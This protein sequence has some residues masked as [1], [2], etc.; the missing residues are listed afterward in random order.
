MKYILLSSLSFLTFS[1]SFAIQSAPFV[2]L[3][4]YL[5]SWYEVASIPA[6]FQK[7]CVKN[8]MAEYRALDYGKIDVVNSCMKKD[9]SIEVANGIAYV[10]KKSTNA[11]LKVSFVP[12]L[13]TLVGSQ[14]NIKF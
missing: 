11:E 4:R 8:T 10:V 3:N 7:K 13:I 6:K 2:D 5:G 14:A 12:F 1:T 9:G